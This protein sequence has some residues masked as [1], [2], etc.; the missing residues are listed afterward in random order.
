MLLSGEAASPKC[1]FK[2]KLIEIKHNLEF[3]FRYTSPFHMLKSCMV[4]TLLDITEVSRIRPG[5]QWALSTHLLDVE[6]TKE[7]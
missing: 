7:L 3:S 6:P 2:H 4:A 1:P 5:T